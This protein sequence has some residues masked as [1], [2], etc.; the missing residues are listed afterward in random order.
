MMRRKKAESMRLL[1]VEKRQKQRVQEMRET[2]KKDVENMSL[3][4]QLRVEVQK[5][6]SKIE[7]TCHN[8]ASVLCGLGITVGDGTSHE[9][10]VAYKKALLKFHTD[11]S[12]SDIRQQVEAEEKF[13]LISRMKDKYVPTL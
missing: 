6:L 12:Q 7:M 5:E 9:V 4:E 10:R 3:K 1:E 8:M 13:K 2:Q 11:T